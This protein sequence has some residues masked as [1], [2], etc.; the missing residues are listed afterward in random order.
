MSKRTAITEVKTGEVTKTVTI[1]L[2][3]AL[4][5]S[6]FFMLMA[7]FFD[8]HLH[9]YALIAVLAAAVISIVAAAELMV[10]HDKSARV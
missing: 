9:E 6:Y 8:K 1:V 3:I 7:D 4:P 5:A 10:W 2:A